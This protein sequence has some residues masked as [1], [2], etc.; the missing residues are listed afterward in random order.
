MYPHPTSPI[1]YLCL[2][3]LLLAVIELAL[4]SQG[5]LP[6]LSTL[7]L[8]LETVGR[9]GLPPWASCCLQFEEAHLNWI[10]QRFKSPLVRQ[11]RH[12][13]MHGIGKAMAY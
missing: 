5:L 12:T 2:G 4:R 13:D 7:L 10:S 8:Q 3:Q 9:G 11:R 1:P 6:Q